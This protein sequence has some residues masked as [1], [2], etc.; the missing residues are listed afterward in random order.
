[1]QTMKMKLKATIEKEIDINDVMDY[2]LEVDPC[3]YNW[4]DKYEMI[5]NKFDLDESILLQ[6]N[7]LSVLKACIGLYADQICDYAEKDL[8]KEIN[9]F[10]Q[11]R[12]E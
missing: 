11:G 1:M 2:L 7:P 5:F 6:Q 8:E 12:K 9:T 3:V 10:Y 4:W